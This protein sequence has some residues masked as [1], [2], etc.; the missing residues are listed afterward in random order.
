[1]TRDRFAVTLYEWHLCTIFSPFGNISHKTWVYLFVPGKIKHSNLT[2]LLHIAIHA[3][4]K[5]S[6]SKCNVNV[7]VCVCFCIDPLSRLPNCLRKS[8]GLSP[9]SDK[10]HVRKTI[11]WTNTQKRH[12]KNTHP[13]SISHVYVLAHQTRYSPWNDLHHFS[14]YLLSFYV[15]RMWKC[16]AARRD[17]TNITTKSNFGFIV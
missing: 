11:M 15:A 7:H 4:P 2:Q 8:H 13:E 14:S 6:T 5:H 12:K 17:S 10:N 9:I 1:M 16:T 3:P